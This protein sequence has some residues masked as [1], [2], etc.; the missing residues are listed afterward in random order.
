MLV[1]LVHVVYATYL[2]VT[3]CA[4]V[5]LT[6]LAVHCPNAVLPLLSSA[7]VITIPKGG[8]NWLDAYTA[9]NVKLKRTKVTNPS[10]LTMTK[11]SDTQDERVLSDHD[12]VILSHTLL[13][14]VSEI[15]MEN[16]DLTLLT[17]GSAQVLNECTCAGWD[18]CSSHSDS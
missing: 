15:P 6:H 9:P 7:C 4:R 13:S 17:D 10:S 11:I 3:T 8:A 1:V 12:W 16:L 14:N 2:T 5:A 18:V